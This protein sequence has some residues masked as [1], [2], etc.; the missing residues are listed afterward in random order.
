MAASASASASAGSGGGIVHDSLVVRHETLT[1][2]RV[3][4]V[5]AGDAAC[6]KSALARLASSHG[7]EH[8][9]AYM[10][11]AQPEWLALAL[12]VPAAALPPG[13]P[14]TLVDLLL[15][16][17]PG[18]STF[19]LRDDAAQRL[20]ATCRAAVLVFDVGSRE[21]FKNVDRWHAKAQA[22]CGG[23]TGGG[24]GGGG[25]VGGGAAGG[26]GG[27]AGGAGP[28]LV[29][30]VGAKSD[31]REAGVERAEVAAE[32]GRACAQRLGALGYVECS[33]ERG[34]DVERPFALIAAAWARRLLDEREEAEAEA[35]AGAGGGGAGGGGARRAH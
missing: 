11:T 35:D 4:A 14:P 9:K 12:R 15:L 2:F 7:R 19:N 23:G 10:C 13:A 18:S 34:V 3:R 33:A 31:L 25:G 26:G 16:D 32:E 17:A 5:V 22:A 30:L 21:S 6:G 27:G 28:L 20:W 1:P 29:V 24:G 8:P